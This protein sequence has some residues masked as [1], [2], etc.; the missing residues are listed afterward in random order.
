[1]YTA[2]NVK[3]RVVDVKKL[4]NE[5]NKEIG[6]TKKTY[7][8]NQKLAI[9]T[10]PKIGLITD[11]C[12]GWD[13]QPFEIYLY[14]EWHNENGGLSFECI[15]SKGYQMTIGDFAD[16]IERETTLKEFMGDRYQYNRRIIANEHEWMRIFNKE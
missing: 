7:R 6:D 10:E 11:E 5:L 14:A 3:V 12:V 1:M 9:V 8:I 4:E 15:P 2:E 13:K 16:Y